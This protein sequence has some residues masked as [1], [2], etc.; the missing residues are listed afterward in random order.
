[1]TPMRPPEALVAVVN[2]HKP[3]AAGWIARL[4]A[5]CAERGWRF[6]HLQEDPGPAAEL[7][8]RPLGLALGGDGTLLHAARWLAPYEVPLL[9]VNLG[10]LGFLTPVTVKGL[11]E[12]LER[13]GAGRYRLQERLRLEAHGPRG[14]YTALNEFALLHT[15]TDVIT[16]VVLYRG[17]TLIASYP[18]DGVIVAT[19]TGS[20][21]YSLAAGGPLLDP[22]LEA[23]VITPLNPHKLGLRPLVLPADVPLRAET[24]GPAAL[25]ADGDI[26]ETLPAGTHLTLRRAAQP[27]RLV[28]LEPEGDWFAFLEEKLSWA[29]RSP[30]KTYY[31]PPAEEG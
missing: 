2:P 6:T 25:L 7:G 4:R 21:A 18:G 10:S 5:W 31:A 1:M 26:L 3:D 11:W 30:G 9:G 19:P 13:I 27:T 29:R 12:A 8:R 20:T 23:V 14:R 24:V 22:H 17:E 16:E 28:Q 15:H